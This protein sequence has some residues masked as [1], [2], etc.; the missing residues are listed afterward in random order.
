MGKG[1]QGNRPFAKQCLSN[2]K[3]LIGLDMNHFENLHDYKN[4]EYYSF[5]KK[6]VYKMIQI[7]NV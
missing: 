4:T 3:A 1:A 5:K 7:L 2:C 6:S